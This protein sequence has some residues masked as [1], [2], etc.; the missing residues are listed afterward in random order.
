MKQLDLFETSR[1]RNGYRVS[2]PSLDEVTFMGG[3]Q[4]PVHSWFRLTPSY[5]PEL[6]RYL[7]KYLKCNDETV[8]LDPFLG[9]GTT[10]IECKK[11]G[12]DCIGVEINPLLQKVSEYELT[13]EIDL[14]SFKADYKELYGKLSEIISREQ[15]ASL[16]DVLEKYKLKVP[17]IHNPFRWWRKNVLRDLLIIRDVVFNL[18]DGDVKNLYWVALSSNAIDCANI[19][20]NHPTITFD[21]GHNRDIDA[22]ADFDEKIEK[23]ITDLAIIHD[24]NIGTYPNIE[25][26]LGNSTVLNDLVGSRRIDRVI[27]S[28]PY[29]NRFSYVHTTRPQL[30]FMD[31]FDNASQSADLDISA[32]GGTWGRATSDLYNIEI[33]PNKDIR[34]T[35]Q[36]IVAELRP[37][38]NLMCNYVVKYFNMVD[39]HIRALKQVISEDF[40][41]AYVVGNSRIKGEEIYTE[42]LLSEIFEIRGFHVDELL[43][44][45]KRGGR[46]KLYETAVCVSLSS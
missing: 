26:I 4:E 27:T 39:D 15:N 38:S 20:R 22:L 1:I 23:I 17:S 35:L 40:R 14:A 32:I 36:N 30:F 29:P 9:K 19:H 28:P 5:S 42:L 44:F 7:L 8:I 3:V 37:R 12:F 18:V 11:L 6:V 25:I 43:T 10:T 2:Y 24:K 41:G 13:W 16:D 34:D 45:R 21:D 46:A 33:E 31:I